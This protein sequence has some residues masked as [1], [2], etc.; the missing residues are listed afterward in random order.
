MREKTIRIAVSIVG[1][2]PLIMHRMAASENAQKRGAKIDPQQEAEAGLYKNENGIFVPAFN[3]LS[4]LREAGK[5]FRVAGKG[6]TTFSKYI[7]GGVLITPDEIPLIS[8]GGW[9][10]DLRNVVVGKSRIV[11]A[12]PSFDDW[13]LDF[14]I[15]IIDEIITPPALKEIIEAAGKYIGLCDFRPIFGRFRV[16]RFE[17][18]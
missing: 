17:V 13:Q 14:E 6:R 3:V 12:R 15:E 8:K 9:K 18:L 1:T 16:D 11:R 7:V 2:R 10:I 4:C 5:D